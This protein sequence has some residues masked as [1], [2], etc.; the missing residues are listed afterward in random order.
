MTGK[1]R[2][3]KADHLLGLS[4]VSYFLAYLYLI[5]CYMFKAS[6]DMAC[7]GFI[8]F[9]FIGASSAFAYGRLPRPGISPEDVEEL[10]KMVNEMKW[11]L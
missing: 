10:E 5:A 11:R 9:A 8:I 2:N 4:I 1:E 3:R 6:E 7:Y